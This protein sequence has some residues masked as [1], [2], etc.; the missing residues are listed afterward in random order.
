MGRS[1]EELVE[2][3]DRA[4]VE[5]WDFGW[6]E[7]RAA[8]ERPSWHYFDLVAE[9]ARG[10]R[11]LLD[12]QTGTG[13]MVAA[14]PSV[15]PLT[16]GTEGYPP[17]VAIATRRLRQRGAHLVWTDEGAPALPFLDASFELVTSR[18]PVETWWSE[19]ARVLHPRGSYL[20]QQVGPHSL[21][22]L[23]E[24]FVGPLPS[25]SR[26]DPA[27][28]RRAAEAAGLIVTDL[29]QERP[30]T[31]F[32]DVGALVYFLRLVVWIVPEFTVAKYR[33]RLREL[34]D[35]IEREGAFRTT[36]SRFLI[37]ARKP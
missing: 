14:L 11:S 4:P 10:V 30:R 18:H 27:L 3:A 17:S 28:A 26:R 13:G 6:L 22:E 31:E 8:E 12:V 35:Y 21:R 7:G 25:A 19:I 23:S 34:H 5:G 36:A 20:S 16:V 32:Y 33:A 9:R 15:P 37:E 2:E 24:F 29:R 1:F